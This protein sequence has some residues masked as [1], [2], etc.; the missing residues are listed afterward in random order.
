ML[1]SVWTPSYGFPG[2]GGPIA[3]RGGRL[4]RESAPGKAPLKTKNVT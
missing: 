4:A 1:V 2:G 3:I